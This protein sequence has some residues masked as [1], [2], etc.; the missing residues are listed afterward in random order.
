MLLKM[1]VLLRWP[2]E[3]FFVI[4]S[5]PRPPHAI[6]NHFDSQK[7]ADELP[8]SRAR[9]RRRVINLKTAC[10]AL[11]TSQILPQLFGGSMVNRETS[12]RL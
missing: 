11:R 12:D 8:V 4:C 9:R 5:W 6:E 10:V 7:R 2:V 1:R 3:K